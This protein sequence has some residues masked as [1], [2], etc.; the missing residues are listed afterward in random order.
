MSKF[1]ISM[2]AIAVSALVAGSA[3]AI[4]F[5]AVW[6]GS[7]AKANLTGAGCTADNTKN[8]DMAVEMIN[9]PVIIDPDFSN[10]ITGPNTGIWNASLFLFGDELDGSG[11]FVISRNGNTVFDAPKKAAV[12]PSDNFFLTLVAIVGEYAVESCSK[13]VEFDGDL[14]TVTKG[15]ATW[16][17]K[18][19]RLS[20]KMD[21]KCQYLDDKGRD[22]TVQLKINSG[23]LEIVN[24]N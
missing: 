19:E 17:K 23:K 24:F 13:L 9:A 10:F 4:E 8:L 16:T 22:K 5:D 7:T 12:G 1:S 3:A 11:T 2:A 14:C 21:M 15:D 20:M 6:I 18:G